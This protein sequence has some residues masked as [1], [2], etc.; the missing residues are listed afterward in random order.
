MDGDTDAACNPLLH[1]HQH[2]H[3]QQPDETSSEPEQIHFK[4]VSE[5]RLRKRLAYLGLFIFFLFPLGLLVVATIFGGLLALSEKDAT[6]KEAFLYV[7][8][9]LLGMANTLTDYAPSGVVTAVV[10]DLYVEVMRMISFG[11][12]L[13]VINLFQVPQSINKF[14][15]K[16]VGNEFLTSLIAL[17]I[18][19][20]AWN[21]CLSA[22]LGC[23]L[24]LAESWHVND[25]I[26]YVLTNLLGLGTPLT[27]VEPTTFH[28]KFVDVLISSLAI[29]YFAI[30]ADY[31]T[32][33]NPSTTVR[34][35]FRGWLG[36][37]GAIDLKKTPELHPLACE[38][39][40]EAVGCTK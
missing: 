37:L 32:T 26:L 5:N 16:F 3:Q 40:Q 28:G 29:G 2:Q 13:A 39:D 21:A 38:N 10:I 20:P 24:A 18:F 23:F 17:G 11:I 31:V 27:D 19:I 14:I 33:L 22:I 1:Q 35:G 12:M 36:K 30:F 6:Y 34:K 8:S 7:I 25:G 15:N 4:G 9:N